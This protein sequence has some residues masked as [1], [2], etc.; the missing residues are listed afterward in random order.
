MRI[1]VLFLVL[2]LVGCSGGSSGGLKGTVTAE[3]GFVF[4]EWDAGGEVRHVVL[5]DGYGMMIFYDAYAE[6]PVCRYELYAYDDKEIFATRSLAD[7]KERLGRI[8]TGQKLYYYNTCAG[9]THH[10]LDRGVLD[11]IKAFC[12]DKGI[13]F[14]EGDDKLFVICTCL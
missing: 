12:A 14:Q 8:G 9:G 1:V 2:F 11:N 7:F 5:R 6:D 4:Y 10:A 13:T 3:D